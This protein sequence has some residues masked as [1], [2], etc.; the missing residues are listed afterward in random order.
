[1]IVKTKVFHEIFHSLCKKVRGYCVLSNT[2]VFCGMLNHLRL[3]IN[4]G[5]NLSCL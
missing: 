1:M 2:E 3:K 5:R 4:V